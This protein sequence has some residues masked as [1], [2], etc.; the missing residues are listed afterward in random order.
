M[1]DQSLVWTLVGLVIQFCDAVF[2]VFLNK[3]I[4]WVWRWA[5]GRPMWARHGKRTIVIVD[6]PCVHQ[7]TEN[8]VSKLYSQGYS[9]CTPD[10][11]GASGLDHFV[12]RFTHRVV[13][14][15]LLAIGRPDGRMCCLGENIYCACIYFVLGVDDYLHDADS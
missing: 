9:F 13:R 8:F 15:V 5:T 7:L 10:V 12:H 2:F 14:G 4:T 1:Q 6:T 11:H 3:I